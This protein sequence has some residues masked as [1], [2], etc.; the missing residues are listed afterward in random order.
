MGVRDI[1]EMAVVVVAA[2][3]PLLAAAF[4]PYL[5][6]IAFPLDQKV[7]YGTSVMYFLLCDLLPSY[8]Q[9]TFWI[10]SGRDRME[11]V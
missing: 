2:A 11:Q 5:T 6:A 9:A 7:T 8:V 3:P 10:F 4:S 1:L